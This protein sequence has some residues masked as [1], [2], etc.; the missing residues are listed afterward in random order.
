MNC[1]HVTLAA[2][3]K[4]ETITNGR[5]TEFQLMRWLVDGSSTNFQSF[6][7]KAGTLDVASP[8]VCISYR[9]T[10]IITNNREM[11]CSNNEYFYTKNLLY[12]LS[13]CYTRELPGG[14]YAFPPVYTQQYTHVTCT[15]IGRKRAG[16]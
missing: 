16:T 2:K 1:K 10:I 5:L 4:K 14:D 12:D 3:M 6:P 13:R 7:K 15:S 8:T 9:Y 11:L